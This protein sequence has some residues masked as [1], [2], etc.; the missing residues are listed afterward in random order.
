MSPYHYLELAQKNIL[1]LVGGTTLYNGA[2]EWKQHAGPGQGWTPFA[3][4]SWSDAHSRVACRALGFT[5]VAGAHYTVSRSRSPSTCVSS[6]S[7]SGSEGTL[8]ECTGLGLSSH[9]GL[10]VVGIQ[11]AGPLEM[12]TL[13]TPTPSATP[14]V[15]SP[16][17]GTSLILVCYS[18]CGLPETAPLLFPL[19]SPTPSSS[20]SSPTRS[21]PPLFLPLLPSSLLPSPPLSSHPLLPYLLTLSSPIFSPSPPLL[22]PFFLP[23]LSL[24]IL[25][26]SPSLSSPLPSPPFLSSPLLPSL[27]LVSLLSPSFPLFLS[28][29]YLLCLPWPHFYLSLSP[30]YP[31]FLLSSL[32]HS[33]HSQ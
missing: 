29:P 10:Q 9:C 20:R 17:R 2:V 4:T 28:S 8:G 22:P 6:L 27:P 13:T 3:S 12:F 18:S 23:S 24:P 11:C 5:T 31:S 19:C 14:P 30:H 21:P 1:R 26:S 7:C 15:V 33:D 16:T 32:Q 25:H